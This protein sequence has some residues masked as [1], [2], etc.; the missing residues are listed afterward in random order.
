MAT[1][2]SR[3]H[4]GY[5]YSIILGGRVGVGKTA[6]FQRLLYD[7]F[8]EE[9]RLPSSPYE[10]GLE[11]GVHCLK[12]NGEEV[13][14]WHISQAASLSILYNYIY[15]YILCV[16]V[17]VCVQVSLWDTGG[18]EKYTAMTANYFRNC[19]AVILVY[20]LEEEDSLFVLRDWLSEARSLNSDQVV[21]ALWGNKSE[22]HSVCLT[23]EVA[24]AFSREN[25]IPAELV[26]QV[27]AQTG[28]GVKE[29]FERLVETV[30]SQFAGVEQEKIRTLEPLIDPQLGQKSRPCYC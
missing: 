15:I 18:L 2:S 17:C 22:S 1:L 28:A 29:A 26:A 4:E 6:L 30:H 25:G 19:Q 14:V 20:S 7:T 9:P 5:Q 24:S 21:P 27:S 13:K 3:V 10:E 23:E 12:I 11:R 8:P 16:C